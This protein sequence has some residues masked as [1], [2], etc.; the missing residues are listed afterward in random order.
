MSN[1][2]PKPDFNALFKLGTFTVNVPS[3]VHNADVNP[4]ENNVIKTNGTYN[5]PNDKSGW[6]SFSVNVTPTITPNVADL[7]ITNDVYDY[8]KEHHD[9]MVILPGNDPTVI[10]ET[11]FDTHDKDYAT[12]LIID[13]NF[14]KTELK[15]DPNHQKLRLSEDEE[16]FE[17][18]DYEKDGD[19]D[20]RVKPKPEP[21]PEPTKN[22]SRFITFKSNTRDIIEDDPTYHNIG[23]FTIVAPI[24]NSIVLPAGTYT[25]DIGIYNNENNTDYLGVKTITFTPSIPSSLSKTVEID[26]IQNNVT[27]LYLPQNDGEK[28]IMPVLSSNSSSNKVTLITDNEGYFK[29][30]LYYIFDNNNN[31]YYLNVNGSDNYFIVQW[32]DG[33]QVINKVTVDCYYDR[34][35]LTFHCNIS[36][37]NDNET[38]TQL[39]DGL[40]NT[41]GNWKTFD[42][43]LDNN[44]N[45]AYTYYKIYLYVTGG[46]PWDTTS[47]INNMKFI[48][49][50]NYQYY[51]SFTIVNKTASDLGTPIIQSYN[52]NNQT[53]SV[54]TSNTNIQSSF[55]GNITVPL[56]SKTIEINSND[57]TTITPSN[58]YYGIKQ[59]EL[60]T[61]VPTIAEALISKIKVNDS[62]IVNLSDFTPYDGDTRI[63]SDRLIYYTDNSFKV[64]YNTQNP[65]V[66]IKDKG[67]YYPLQ[68]TDQ[69]ETILELYDKNETLLTKISATNSTPGWIHLYL[70]LV[71]KRLLNFG[72]QPTIDSIN[73]SKIRFYWE[74]R[75]DGHKF[76]SYYTSGTKVTSNSFYSGGLLDLFYNPDTSE[77]FAIESNQ[78]TF[79]YDFT[80]GNWYRMSFSNQEMWYVSQTIMFIY[81]YDQNNNKVFCMDCDIIGSGSIS[82]YKRKLPLG[83][84]FA[85]N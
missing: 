66:T 34:G 81:C 65:G 73:I 50:G 85:F 54:S 32:N 17:I 51:D 55:T 41:G 53:V 31:T 39:Y 71:D 33:P 45:N 1:N 30:E 20:V 84:K 79:S 29:N 9:G 22:K 35:S 82:S 44:T 68:F 37:S 7:M 46:N 80:S 3:D 2:N 16:D 63:E 25:F 62:N 74:D 19:Y 24:L 18:Y 60:T 70:Y 26:T 42:L 8:V 59:I 56:E 47:R 38:Y 58:N 49:Y 78:L 15:I 64:Y 23:S 21:E 36:G 83:Y 5:V 52:T 76:S 13:L 4:S 67:Y 48:Q 12:G 28:N 14:L 11:M 43:L 27:T 72:N 57:T 77:Y 61:T 40:C 69:T 6:N 10:E 75:D